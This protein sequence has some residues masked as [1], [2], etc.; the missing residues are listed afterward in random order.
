MNYYHADPSGQ[1]VG[2]YALEELRQLF[3]R[4]LLPGN[5]Q[6]CAEGKTDWMPLSSMLARAL[7]LPPLPVSDDQPLHDDSDPPAY[8]SQSVSATPPATPL[9]EQ[10]E[11]A[12]HPVSPPALPSSN[13]QEK[14]STYQRVAETVGMVPDLSLRRN[15]LQ[16]VIV[17]L[18]TAASA[19]G[20]WFMGGVPLAQGAALGGM[21]LGILVS[22][23][24]LMFLG[25]KK[26]I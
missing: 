13:S 6:V 24:V 1:V 14:G 21:L 4:G 25:W 18:V 2:P 5:V 8:S 22:G 10:T 7:P 9:S 15:L 20:G 26:G 16:L 17:A 3:E 11:S 19:L 12:A 23:T